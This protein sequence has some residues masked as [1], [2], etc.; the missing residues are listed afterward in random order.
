MKPGESIKPVSYL[1]AH[2]SEI[3]REIS[4]S[5]NPVYITQYGK[6]KAVL[7]D[8]YSYEQTQE[9]LAM[10]KL[11]ALSAKD[12]AEGRYKPV[13]QVFKDLRKRMSDQPDR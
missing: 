9:S 8:V 2:A 12:H 3:I 13:K 11:L 4:E 7:Q 6:A 10:L 1:K 5:R